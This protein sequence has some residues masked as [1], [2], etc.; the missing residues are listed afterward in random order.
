MYITLCMTFI[1]PI[2]IV[3]CKIVISLRAG[4][5]YPVHHTLCHGTQFLW[6]R[7]VIKC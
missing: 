5:I 7:L 2:S 4:Q 6:P 3:K 1:A